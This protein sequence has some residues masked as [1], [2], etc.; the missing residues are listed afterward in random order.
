MVKEREATSPPTHPFL[1]DCLLLISQLWNYQG[2]GEIYAPP[3]LA[4]VVNNEQGSMP[5][6]VIMEYGFLSFGT[7]NMKSTPF[8]YGI[9]FYCK[10]IVEIS[11]A[12]AREQLRSLPPRN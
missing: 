5:Y 2:R 10:N 4:S 7:S 12:K 11:S 9:Y 8:L 1:V 3:R 6:K